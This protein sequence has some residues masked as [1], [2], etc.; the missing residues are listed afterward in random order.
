[1]LLAVVASALA[2]T[3]VAITIDDLP[4]VGQVRPGDTRAAAIDRIVAQLRARDVPATGFVVCKQIGEGELARWTDVDLANHST[5]HASVDALG[6]KEFVDDVNACRDRLEA[7]APVRYFRYPYLRTGAT[8]E[9]RDA[10]ARDLRGTTVAP[11]TIDTSD[12]ALASYYAKAEDPRAITD[13]YVDHVL[14]A[15]RHYRSLGRER[16][17]REVSHV[18]LLHANALAADHLGTV[19]DAL[20]AD[21]FSFVPLAEALR[22]PIY[23]QRDDY[24]GPI[25]M[26]WLYRIAPATPDAWAFDQGQE[27][28]IRARF[29]GAP[30]DGPV[31]IGN[32]LTVRELSPGVAVVTHEAPF[33]S[34]TL[35]AAV[36]DALVISG[37]PFTTGATETLL[38]WA[39]V[40]FG[41]GA[42]TVVHSHFHG[43]GGTAGTVAYR[44]AGAAVY[45]SDRTRELLETRGAAVKALTLRSIEDSATR[46]A[47]DATPWL[48]GDHDF[49]LARGITLGP[50]QVVFP[51]AAHSPD[52][53]V[54]WIPRLGVLFGGCMV[55]A[56]T[57]GN[58]SDA[59]LAAWPKA[60]A[61]LRELRPTF[62][63]PGHGTR[64]DP[65]LLDRTDELVCAA[66]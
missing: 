43:D 6:A 51:G 37:S 40:R 14:A 18:L 17:G 64:F 56:D 26:S 65:G 22:D 23:A 16:A 58:L 45:S 53:V 47:V 41:R 24:A 57:L 62:V 50:A 15:A 60:V 42:L 12:W 5:R 61:R 33:P 59:D 19:L 21:D 52:N 49:P 44:A 32:D 25:G 13:A 46:A 63:V 8:P 9:L 7:N 27:T 48:A 1:M 11:V 35:V 29:G 28:A 55:R 66:R 38:A 2:G 54:V 4:F 34:N 39:R 30:P 20:R 10:V 31:A 3:P 36:D